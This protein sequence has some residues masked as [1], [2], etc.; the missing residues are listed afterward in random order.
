MRKG[1]LTRLTILD[2][3]VAAARYTGL[4]GLTIG[5]LASRIDMSKSGLYAHFDSKEALQL[6]TMAHHREQFVSEVVR[7]ALGAPRGTPR[8]RALITNWMQWY[9][10]PGGCLF[11]SSANEFDDIEGALHDQMVADENDLRDCIAQVL[12]TLISTGDISAGSDVDQLTQEVFGIL[13][14]YNWMNRILRDSR[15]G[16]H[17]WT[18]VD[19]LLESIRP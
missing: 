14:A 5:S 11:L 3:A 1:E 18:A 15:A 10:H 6:A 17:A 12:G 4:S 13:L 9:E 2:E 16:S 7:P 19:R 8:L